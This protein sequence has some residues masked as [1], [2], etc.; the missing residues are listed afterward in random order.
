MV[1]GFAVG[2]AATVAKFSSSVP[3]LIVVPPVYVF[4]LFNVN[5]AVEA[6]PSTTLP[7][8]PIVLFWA[9]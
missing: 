3:P 5:V 1:G 6:A 9:A 7:I 4:A 8:P 2:L